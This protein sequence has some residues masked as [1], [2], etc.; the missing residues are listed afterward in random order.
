MDNNGIKRLRASFEEFFTTLE[1]TISTS[2]RL[3]AIEDEIITLKSMVRNITVGVSKQSNPQDILEYNDAV[4]R[5]LAKVMS[6]LKLSPNKMAKLSN[7]SWGTVEKFLQGKEP[8]ASWTVEKFEKC[9]RNMG[10]KIE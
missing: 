9:I 6:D 3:G 1:N 10:Y 5:A 7:S 8:V 4:R 2:E